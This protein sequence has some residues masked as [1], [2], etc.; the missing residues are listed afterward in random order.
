MRLIASIINLIDKLI[1]KALSNQSHFKK[2]S[3]P[4]IG[5]IIDSNLKSI[6]NKLFIKDE[7]PLRCK[8]LISDSLYFI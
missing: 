4:I 2:T 1:L 8:L 7:I 6:N 3:N 5:S